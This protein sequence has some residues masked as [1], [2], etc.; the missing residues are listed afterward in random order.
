MELQCHPHFRILKSEVN[1][2]RNDRSWK[3]LSLVAS[4]FIFCNWTTRL[5][6][7]LGKWMCALTIK[8]CTLT[9]VRI[10]SALSSPIDIHVC[11]PTP[12]SF[13]LCFWTWELKYTTDNSTPFVRPAEVS[14]SRP[15]ESRIMKTLRDCS[16]W[17]KSVRHF[18]GTNLA[19]KNLSRPL[20]IAGKGM[21]FYYFLSTSLQISLR[22]RKT[23]HVKTLKK[24]GD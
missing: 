21:D 11:M 7:P 15:G 23:C 8:I 20:Q 6:P 14:T 13:R 19:K 24:R 4:N 17:C 22:G 10:P 2:A 1:A 16:P 12:E 18:Y 9:F 5:F 3:C